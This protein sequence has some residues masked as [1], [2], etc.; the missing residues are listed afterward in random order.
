MINLKSKNFQIYS[1]KIQWEYKKK[2]IIIL[3]LISAT[4][5]QNRELIF[6][7]KI[8]LRNLRQGKRLPSPRDR[9]LFKKHGES[10]SWFHDSMGAN[11]CR[12]KTTLSFVSLSL[13]FP[14]PSIT[15][16][17]LPSRTFYADLIRSRHR[18]K[19]IVASVYSRY[20]P[21]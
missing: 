2:K 1:F 10:F 5:P 11:L 17:L 13:F 6:P 21:G 15:L 8:N 20:A 9:G 14:P 16:R 19:Y 3:F 4:Y 12:P 7:L 18:V